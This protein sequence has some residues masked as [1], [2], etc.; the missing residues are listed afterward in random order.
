M[1]VGH[2]MHTV[3]IVFPLTGVVVSDTQL[4]TACIGFWETI[5]AV[6]DSSAACAFR[7]ECLTFQQSTMCCIRS[8]K[9]LV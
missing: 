7:R 9:V 3:E 6:S 5:V 2:H 1:T 8:T 4:E